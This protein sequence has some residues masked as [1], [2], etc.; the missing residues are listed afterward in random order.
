MSGIDEQ[1]VEL[2][3]EMCKNNNFEKVYF[4]YRKDYATIDE[5]TNEISVYEEDWFSDD[6]EEWCCANCHR[7]ASDKIVEALERHM[8]EM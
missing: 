5:D 1:K 4:G 2:I 3:C 7:R 6:Y 8:M